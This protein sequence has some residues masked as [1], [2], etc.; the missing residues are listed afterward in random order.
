M[1]SRFA[2]IAPSGKDVREVDDADANTEPLVEG[3]YDE[4][5][6]QEY[7]AL[8]DEILV[9]QPSKGIKRKLAEVSDAASELPIY[10]N[11][12]AN[13]LVKLLLHL[14]SAYEDQSASADATSEVVDSSL[15]D[16][17]QDAE[18]PARQLLQLVKEQ[19]KLT[20]W[21]T[22][23]RACFLLAV[24]CEVP[25]AQA[26]ARQLLRQDAAVYASIKAVSETSQGGKVLLEKVNKL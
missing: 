7:E 10:E 23:N 4:E 16:S 9:E 1:R 15:W 26:L 12:V 24:A 17:S 25:S 8:A 18:S 11:S 14:E 5:G 13:V 21:L 6:I 19:G 22:C 2:Q 20:Q 3:D